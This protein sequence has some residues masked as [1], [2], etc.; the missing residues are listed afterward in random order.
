MNVGSPK[1]RAG[2]RLKERFREETG[3]AVLV[4][5]E[6]VFA[7]QGL[8]GASMARIAE[9]AGLAVGTLYNHFQDRDTLLDAVLADRKAALLA[10]L[11]ARMALIADQPFS[12][13]LEAFLAAIFEHLE[14]H[15]AF[16]QVV[17]MT[18]HRS[19]AKGGEHVRALHERMSSLLKIGQ[20]QGALRTDADHSF[21][22]MLLGLT[23]AL[24]L[25][26]VFGG[27]RLSPARSARRGAEL[28]LHGAAARP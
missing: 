22:V 21:A 1:P 27:K 20:R 3:K 6:A 17:F 10:G 24:F 14:E 23:R 7:E 26:Q 2:Q 18:E 4:A 28:F 9:R 8:H 25:S 11:D 12:Q 13:Q 19:S 15:R 16:L 5:A